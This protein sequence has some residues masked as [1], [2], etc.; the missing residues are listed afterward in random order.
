MHNYVTGRAQPL[1]QQT[2]IGDRRV[3]RGQDRLRRIRKTCVIDVVMTIR[4]IRWQL[5]T[6]QF[7]TRRPRNRLTASSGLTAGDGVNTR[8]DTGNSDDKLPTTQAIDSHPI[9]QFIYFV[10]IQPLT[11]LRLISSTLAALA[12][13]VQ[14]EE[15]ML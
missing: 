4:C 12:A 10:L 13:S 11:S 5:Q 1:L 15:V 2:V 6:R 7:G 9:L 14:P 8:N 3:R